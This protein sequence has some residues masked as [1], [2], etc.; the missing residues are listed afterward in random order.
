MQLTWRVGFV[1]L[2][3]ASLLA[4]TS[5]NSEVGQ[6]VI[7]PFEF[8]TESVDSVTIQT[9]TVLQADTFVTSSDENI[10]VGQ[11]NDPATGRLTARSFTSV[12][13]TPIDIKDQSQ[14][15]LDSLVLE[16]GYAFSYGDT[17]TTPFNLALHQLRQPLPPNVYYN[18]N[19][20][21]YLPT[22]LLQK[23]FI[24]HP[25]SGTRQV[26]FRMPD[27]LAQEFWDRLQN[28]TITDAETMSSLWPGFAYV[29]NSTANAFAGFSVGTTSGLRLYYHNTDIN[30]TA[31]TVQFPISPIHFCQL[32]GQRA[33]TPLQSLVSR[34]DQVSSAK[35][36]NATFVAVGAGLL[37]RIEFPF[38]NQFNKPSQYA[39]LNKA[40]LVLGPIRRS[41][42]DNAPPPD[43]LVLYR[44][45]SQNEFLS[46][47]AAGAAGEVQAIA[48]YAY[49]PTALETTDAYTFDLTQFISQI[50]RG[51]APNRPLLLTT[52]GQATLKTLVRRVA[53]G[54]GQRPTDKLTLRMFITSG[55]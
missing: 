4:C 29:S 34:T 38:L 15:R 7:N 28:G 48:S 26:R 23:Q 2:A 25:N 27:A 9:S 39:G 40:L 22:P 55:M 21:D 51:Q 44:T 43:Q 46:I 30:R 6:S 54:S 24:L 45:N 41:L 13:Y 33:G 36:G 49:D 35:T 5:G 20:A 1:L 53:L 11:W 18:N 37:T 10:L 31:A 3:G 47:V 17:T 52:N 50:I 16:L 14:L 42:N 8:Q 19:S 12:A 32:L